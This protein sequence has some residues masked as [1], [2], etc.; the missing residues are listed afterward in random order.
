VYW[1]SFGPTNVAQNG[2]SAHLELGRPSEAIKAAKQLHFPAGH[3]RGRVGMHWVNM[4]RAYTQ[5]GKA[6]GALTALQR[7]RTAAPQLLRY[8]PAVRDVVG[9]LVRRQ[10]RASE[11]VASLA[12]W[13]G[14]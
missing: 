6:E 1:L 10:R 3:N 5:I 2:V 8:H 4:A 13:V 14:M 7:G 9:T 12:A 11:G